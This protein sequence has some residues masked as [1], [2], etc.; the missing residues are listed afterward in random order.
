MTTLRD[1]LAKIDVA[2]KPRVLS[3]RHMDEYWVID[4]HTGGPEYSYW[5]LAE[6][7]RKLSRSG[8]LATTVIDD[9][10][11]SHPDW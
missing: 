5:I 7:G 10:K 2:V 8:E 11:K 6:R 1:E 9:F 4:L 3:F